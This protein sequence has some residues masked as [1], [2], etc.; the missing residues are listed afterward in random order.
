MFCNL[1]RCIGQDSYESHQPIKQHIKMFYHTKKACCVF[2]SN[3][4]HQW[5]FIY[6]F[7]VRQSRDILLTPKSCLGASHQLENQQKTLPLCFPASVNRAVLLQ[8][9]T[10]RLGK[11]GGLG[12]VG[13]TVTSL[14][15]PTA[16]ESLKEGWVCALHSAH[17]W[18][19]ERER[20]SATLDFLVNVLCC[21][22]IIEAPGGGY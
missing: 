9:E 16:W 21:M 17:H 7:G 13:Q 5:P 20:L 15:Y 8:L 3:M 2:F 1:L 12:L 19:K 22:C 4:C 11:R 14:M 10:S 6:L 18:I